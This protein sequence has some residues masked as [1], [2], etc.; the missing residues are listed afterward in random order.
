MAMVA[1]WQWLLAWVLVPL[2]LV[3]WLVLGWWHCFTSDRLTGGLLLGLVACAAWLTLV[4]L[5][6]PLRLPQ[7]SGQ[8]LPPFRVLAFVGGW[9]VG[10]AWAVLVVLDQAYRGD[11]NWPH[12]YAQRLRD[13][14]RAGRQQV[15]GALGAFQ[16]WVVLLLLIAYLVAQV[17]QPLIYSLTLGTPVGVLLFLF[18]WRQPAP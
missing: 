14:K 15:V 17:F 7:I 11:H 16:L 5:G 4:R 12:E 6:Y 8:P 13:P 2:L 18:I 9:V 10:F 1:D 3:A